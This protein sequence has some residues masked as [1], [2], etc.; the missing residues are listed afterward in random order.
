MGFDHLD[1]LPPICSLTDDVVLFLIEAT[2]ATLDFRYTCVAQAQLPRTC[3]KRMAQVHGPGAGTM[4]SFGSMAIVPFHHR[5]GPRRGD[6][7][8]CLDMCLRMEICVSGP[9]PSVI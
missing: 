1:R 9:S 8:D 7:A 3:P 4:G 2:E 5:G 6:F